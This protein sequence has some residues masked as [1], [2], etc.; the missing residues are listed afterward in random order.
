M[1]DYGVRLQ[2]TAGEIFGPLFHHSVS[3]VRVESIVNGRELR[4]ARLGHEATAFSRHSSG[5]GIRDQSWV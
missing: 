4:E 1:L 5:S 3:L 2:A